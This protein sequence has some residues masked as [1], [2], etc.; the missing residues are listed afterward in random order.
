MH[1]MYEKKL[2]LQAESYIQLKVAYEEL[3]EVYTQIIYIY[4]CARCG[5]PVQCNLFRKRNNNCVWYYINI[6]TQTV[7][8]FPRRE[9]LQ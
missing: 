5:T 3:S 2:A 9:V 6:D 8:A 4:M 1:A 7:P